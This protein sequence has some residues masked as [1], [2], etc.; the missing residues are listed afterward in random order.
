[1][2]RAPAIFARPQE[3]DEAEGRLDIDA[4]VR[5][6][7]EGA[8]CIDYKFE[9]G[10][11]RAREISP[12]RMENRRAGKKTVKRQPAAHEAASN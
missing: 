2:P 12:R 1:M 5:L 8:T 3:L 4:L 10:E 6:G 7:L 9:R 11:V